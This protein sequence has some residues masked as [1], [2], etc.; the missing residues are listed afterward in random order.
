[1]HLSPKVVTTIIPTYRRP[2]LLRRAVMS[3]LNQTYPHVLACVYD[4]ASGDETEAVVAELARRDDRVRYHRHSR[5]IGSYPNF[6]FGIEQ[7]ETPFF[8][9]LSDDDLLAPKFYETA[10]AA[11]ERYPEAGVACLP[12][13]VVD[14]ELNVITRPIHIPAMKLYAPGEALDGMVRAD[15]PGTWTAILFRRDVRDSIGLIGTDVG[16]SA[17]SGFVFY[18]AARFPVVVAPGVGGILMA[19][20]ASTSG[21]VP[22]IGKD[23][24]V[25]W[26]AMLERIAADKMV[27]NFIRACLRQHL[28]QDYRKTGLMQVAKSL[29]RGD[30]VY[31]RAAARG[32]KECGYPVT[33]V[34]LG[35]FVWV[36]EK[37]R[38]QKAAVT[39]RDVRRH[40]HG[41]RHKTLNDR[42]GH[43]VAFARQYEK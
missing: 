9:L 10:L 6:N 20:D 8:S 36:F 24:M 33:G 7:V 23:Y 4:N 12:T 25:W 43:L 27:P 34:L 1:M 35:L 21:T 16:P 17:D 41:R 5:N 22:P 26:D 29:A 18:A 15:I 40:F 13:L 28:P 3:V 32:V 14:A 38:M 30:Y 39:I 37:F 11:F 31:A 42:Y 19:H 2:Q